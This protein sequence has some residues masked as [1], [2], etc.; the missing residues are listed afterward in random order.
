MCWGS[1]A[2]ALLGGIASRRQSTHRTA[3]AYAHSH[4][5]ARAR[6]AAVAAHQPIYATSPPRTC[7][8]SRPPRCGVN[9][10]RR[11]ARRPPWLG[12]APPPRRRAAAPPPP[13]PPVASPPAASI[14]KF[15]C[16]WFSCRAYLGLERAGRAGL[17]SRLSP[18]TLDSAGRGCVSPLAI[19]SDARKHHITSG[20]VRGRIGTEPRAAGPAPKK[21]PIAASPRA[22]A[23]CSRVKRCVTHLPFR[24]TKP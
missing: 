20:R 16:R 11:D 23:L 19:V 4:P 22:P 17:C 10:R 18:A 9:M 7:V 14:G 1:G 13:P 3:S 5:R 12:V 8:L 24:C 15:L 21:Q 2:A 6:P